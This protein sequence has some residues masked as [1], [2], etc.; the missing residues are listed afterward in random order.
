L[1]NNK[2]KN[3]AASVR[4]RLL[5]K[6]RAEK[7]PFNELLQY[8]AMERFLYRLSKSEHKDKFILKGAM[9]LRVWDVSM[10]RPTK[11]IDFLGITSNDISN[12]IGLLKDVCRVPVEPDGLNFD[13]ESFSGE[14]IKEDADYEGARILFIGYLDTARINMQIDVGFDDKVTPRAKTISYPVLLDYPAPRIKTYNKE[15][16]IAEKC[17]AMI[18]LG[19]LNSRMKDF[20]DIYI[21]S[22]T[23]S[24]DGNTLVRAIKAT[25]KQRGTQI[26]EGKPLALTDE[27]ADD[28]NKNIQWKAFISRNNLEDFGFDF[29]QLIKALND[30][31]SYVTEIFIIKSNIPVLYLED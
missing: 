24:F 18:K 10:T 3:V 25:F 29:P 27:F 30:F 6:A 23:F 22:K 19:E 1:T 2:P 31:L 21:L 7:R 11:D 13:I 16:L 9:M 8:Y 4:Q 12:I 17:E 15:T 26:P 20:Y 14:V 28:A 5:N